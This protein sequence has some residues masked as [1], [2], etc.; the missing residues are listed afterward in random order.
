[1]ME[2]WFDKS[3]K[4]KNSACVQNNFL[5]VEAVRNGKVS[6]DLLGLTCNTAVTI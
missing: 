1:M 5:Q 3:F 2:A 4:N 6:V